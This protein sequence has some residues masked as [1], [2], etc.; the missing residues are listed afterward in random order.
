M[1]LEQKR[2]APIL[3]WVLIVLFSAISCP[4]VVSAQSRGAK[5]TVLV[6]QALIK[7]GMSDSAIVM[8]THAL[9]TDSSDIALLLTLADAQGEA[10]QMK[11]RR[12]TLGK[13]LKFHKRSIEAQITLSE[14][15][16]AA[17][18]LDSAAYFAQE[19]L[20]NS[21]RTSSA[22]YYLLGRVHEQAGRADSA[23]F[24]YRGALML[25]P[26]GELF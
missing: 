17:K 6:A 19:A 4:S 20:A 26:V 25:L 24:Y 1:T 14:D 2:I 3:C 18:Q 7:D 5:S 23:L 15:F 8:L 16:L 13:V 22:G 9:K 12:A 10:R 11:G 21:G